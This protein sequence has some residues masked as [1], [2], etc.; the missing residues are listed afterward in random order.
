MRGL[1]RL[2][3][4]AIALLCPVGIAP[5][6]LLPGGA[7]PSLPGVGELTRPVADAARGIVASPPR[8]EPLD[9]ARRLRVEELL[10][11]EAR[12]VELDP[13][14]EPVLRGE[15][16]AMG[17]EAT[18]RDAV[19]AAGFAVVRAA[20]EGE[21]LGIGIVVLRD[22]R[23]RDA[24]RAMQALRAAAPGAEFAY[25]HLYLPAGP[26]VPARGASPSAPPAP[27][28]LRVG[29]V[30]GGVAASAVRGMRVE[31][32]GCDAREIAGPHG[33]AVAARLA[34]GARGTLYAADLWC[35]DR[36][37]RATL[38]LVQALGWMARE[39][40]PVVN[41]SLV[42]PDNPVL[43]RAV[44]A[45]VERGHVIVAAVGNDGPA[46]PPLYPAAYA[47][48]IG[49]SAVDA[50]LRVLPEAGS[51]PQVDFSAPGVV[52]PR[53]RGTSFA[54]PVVARA[55]ALLMREPSPQLARDVQRALAARARDLGA[56]GRDARYGEGLIAA[57]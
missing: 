23:R 9:L 19:L 50:K 30:D 17:L 51:G 18:E 6:Q 33:T 28:T 49:V 57:D 5:A 48:V 20:D 46:A 36:V 42:G 22:T 40:V 7:A 37:G 10:R 3:L 15:F 29:L 12:R 44:K 32:L 4:L 13:R 35:G 26:A 52:A 24:G 39:R 14:G 2:P 54:A 21:A 31:R 53:M 41:V 43:A 55:A 27:A 11:R 25:Q 8:R 47:G 38:G 45:M 56:P 16:L 34:A 1:Y